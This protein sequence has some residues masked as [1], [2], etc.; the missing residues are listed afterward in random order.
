MSDETYSSFCATHTGKSVQVP[1]QAFPEACYWDGRV[2]V[3]HTI[4][5]CVSIE[6]RAVY[7]YANKKRT[8]L[9]IRGPCAR[10]GGV[11]ERDT[12]EHYRTVHQVDAFA[13]RVP[14]LVYTDANEFGQARVYHADADCIHFK[15]VRQCT[16]LDESVLRG[17]IPCAFCN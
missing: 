16:T 5:D 17:D 10:F 11:C 4:P 9:E 8:P 14:G 12:F 3:M 1:A 13:P 2:G 6:T 15:A 7:M